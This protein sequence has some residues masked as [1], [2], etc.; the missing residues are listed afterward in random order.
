M[1]GVAKHTVLKLLKDM[2]CAAA[3]YHD[4]GVHT[5]RRSPDASPG[6]HGMALKERRLASRRGAEKNWGRCWPEPRD[7][8]VGRW[9][10]PPR[11]RVRRLGREPLFKSSSSL[12]WQLVPS[13]ER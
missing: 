6:L 10:P 9:P 4:V 5:A 13:Q 8:L 7:L 11:D 2:G 1:A 12:S 3:S